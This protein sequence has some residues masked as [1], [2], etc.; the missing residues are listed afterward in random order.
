MGLQAEGWGGHK[1]SFS[2][3]ALRVNVFKSMMTVESKPVPYVIIVLAPQITWNTVTQP[4]KFDYHSWEESPYT[5]TVQRRSS[6]VSASAGRT[7]MDM[8]LSLQ[9]SETHSVP[10]Q[11]RGSPM[12]GPP[13]RNF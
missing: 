6:R 5:D 12:Y 7:M 4:Q 1:G 2:Q 13:Q 8:P 3:I 10:V 11:Y 9:N